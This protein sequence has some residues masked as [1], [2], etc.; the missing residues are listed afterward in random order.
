MGL[1]SEW[2]AFEFLR[3]RHG[4]AADETC[5]VS[6]NRAHFF[7]GDEGDD[8][9]G[10]DFCVKTPQAE[11]LYE[12]KSS[13]EDTCEFEL[14]PNEMRVAASVSRRSRRRYRILLTFR[15]SF[16]RTAG[17]SWSCQIPWP[18]RRVAASNKSVTGRSVSG[19]SIPGSNTPR[20]NARPP[21]L[22]DAHDTLDA[23]VAA[24]YGW[25]AGD[26]AR[27][28]W[29]PTEARQCRRV[30]KHKRTQDRRTGPSMSSSIIIIE[31]ATIKGSGTR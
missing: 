9:A 13:L 6:G 27:V 8:A 12:V 19:S 15:S 26:P 11:W 31:S 4:E 16:R 1:A 3:R 22:V 30:Q 5:W 14:T 21:W 18:M 29:T 24:A 25:S 10:Y 28:L 2:L 23:A 17:S 7:G 20:C